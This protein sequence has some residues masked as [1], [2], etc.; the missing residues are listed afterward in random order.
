MDPSDYN[1]KRNS[2]Y[3]KLDIND[4]FKKEGFLVLNAQERADMNNLLKSL[5]NEKGSRKF[6]IVVPNGKGEIAHH[7]DME[8]N[9]LTYRIIQIRGDGNCLFNA[10]SMLL[11][12]DQDHGL[13]LK[14]LA[15]YFCAEYA[16]WGMMQAQHGASIMVDEEMKEF[17][18]EN[19]K[20]GF[21]T[22]SSNWGSLMEAAAL[23]HLLKIHV[24][25]ADRVS[26]ITYRFGEPDIHVL[27]FKI[28][29]FQVGILY[30][31]LP[32]IHYEF[33]SMNMR[34]ARNIIQSISSDAVMSRGFA[35]EYIDVR[36]SS[37][38]H[39]EI[40]RKAVT[41]LHDIFEY[42]G[43]VFCVS[44]KRYNQKPTLLDIQRTYGN[45]R[46]VLHQSVEY[47]MPMIEVGLNRME[48]KH[49][50]PILLEN[51]DSRYILKIYTANNNPRFSIFREFEEKDVFP[52]VDIETKGFIFKEKF[53]STKDQIKSELDRIRSEAEKKFEERIKLY[54]DDK[55]VLDRL[56]RRVQH[57]GEDEA[58]GL[59]DEY[60]RSE[61]LVPE[62]SEYIDELRKH[63]EAVDSGGLKGGEAGKVLNMMQ[64]KLHD[65]FSSTI[66][67]QMGL[68]FRGGDVN[69]KDL[70]ERFS[71]RGLISRQ[72]DLEDM[73]RLTPD[74]IISV[75]VNTGHV[76]A[77]E[78]VIETI[79]PGESQIYIIDFTCSVVP[80]RAQNEKKIK[81]DSIQKYMSEIGFVSDVIAVIL[82]LNKTEVE[83][84]LKNSFI[85]DEIDQRIKEMATMFN[86]FKKQM[87]LKF[88]SDPDFNRTV[89]RDVIFNPEAWD[90][91]FSLSINDDEID[92]ELEE[93][94]NTFLK[95]SGRE[96]LLKDLFINYSEDNPKFGTLQS[97]I[98]RIVKEVKEEVL[99]EREK[100]DN[101]FKAPKRKNIKD[102]LTKLFKD[103]KDYYEEIYESKIISHMPLTSR[104]TDLPEGL[105]DDSFQMNQ[106]HRFSKAIQLADNE[107]EIIRSLKLFFKITD[108]TDQDLK[109]LKNG[110]IFFDSEGNKI[111]SADY[112]NLKGKEISPTEDDFIVNTLSI[113]KNKQLK[114]TKPEK[115][116]DYMKLLDSVKS[117][118]GRKRKENDDMVDRLLDKLSDKIES[119][120]FW[121][122]EARNHYVEEYTLLREAL[123]FDFI[124][125]GQTLNTDLGDLTSSY[126]KVNDFLKG[127]FS[128]LEDYSTFY[129]NLSF[130]SSLGTKSH[131]LV[132]CSN[133]NIIGFTFPSDSILK[134]GSKRSYIILTLVPKDNPLATNMINNKYTVYDCGSDLLYVTKGKCET[135]KTLAT[136][137]VTL[138]RFVLLCS[139]ILSLVERHAKEVPKFGHI[140]SMLADLCML[141][142]N[143]NINNSSIFDNLRY[144]ISNVLSDFSAAGEYIEEKLKVPCKNIFQVYILDRS[145]KTMLTVN[146]EASR[147]KSRSAK[148]DE[149]SEIIYDDFNLAECAVSSFLIP[150]IKYDN[151][152]ALLQEVVALFFSSPKG[153]HDPFH[154]SVKLHKTP[155]E[156]QDKIN[157]KRDKSKK[158][159]L[160]SFNDFN[161]CERHEINVDVTIAASYLAHEE[162]SADSTFL[163]TRLKGSD[164]EKNILIVPTFT[165]TRSMLKE[166]DFLNHKEIKT[167]SD[168]AKNY[169]LDHQSL[170][171]IAMYENDIKD[172]L[173]TRDSVSNKRDRIDK[174]TR[175]LKNKIGDEVF[176]N[177]LNDSMKIDFANGSIVIKFE[178]EHINR[179]DL[180]L[181]DLKKHISTTVVSEVLERSSNQNLIGKTA[182]DFVKDKKT[183]VYAIRPKMQ[184]TQNDREIYV[185]N[186]EAKTYG[187]CIETVYK[188][189][190][191][192]HDYEKISSPGD[193][194]ILDM[195]NQF[196]RQMKWAAHQLEKGAD[197]KDLKVLHMNLDFTKW[198]PKDNIL[199]YIIL[200][201]LNK[202]LRKNEKRGLIYCLIMMFRKKLFID[203]KLLKTMLYNRKK[204]A[205]D[206]D[207]PDCVFEKMT[208]NFTT[209]YVDVK[210]NW[211][212]GQ[213]NYASSF[214]HAG[215]MEL[216]KLCI[217]EIYPI[218]LSF[219]NVHSDDNQT[220]LSVVSTDSYERVVKNS[221]NI[222]MTI[223]KN[224]TMELSTKKCYFSRFIKEFVSQMNIAGEQHFYWVKPLMAIVSGLP[225]TTIY[226]DLMSM[227]SK[228]SEAF[229]KGASTKSFRL[230][231]KL[232]TKE[233]G[234]IYGL[235][236][237][238]GN[239]LA[240]YFDVEDNVLPLS[241][242]GI[243]DIPAEIL[244]VCGP[245]A[246]DKWTLM[247]LLDTCDCDVNRAPGRLPSGNEATTML[248]LF[249]LL[250]SLSE[251]VV[252]DEDTLG[253]G[254]LNPF[255]PIRYKLR[256]EN[257][258]NPYTKENQKKLK[259]EIEVIK[260]DRPS[261]S[262]IK[263]KN[264]EDLLKYYKVLFQKD[265]FKSKLSGQSPDSLMLHKILNKATGGNFSLTNCAFLH[266]LNLS[267]KVF[268]SNKLCSN[269]FDWAEKT[270]RKMTVGLLRRFWTTHILSDS[271]FCAVWYTSSKA[272]DQGLLQVRNLIP[273]KLAKVSNENDFVN[274]MND[275]ILYFFDPEAFIKDKRELN[276]P[277]L[278]N[279]DLMK[280]LVVNP[281]MVI[282]SFSLIINHPAKY[283]NLLRAFNEISLL[284]DKK[285]IFKNSIED[286]T[287]SLP[288]LPST[289]MHE[290]F[291]IGK[292]DFGA[293]NI[294]D[295]IED[296]EKL[297][298]KCMSK[299]LNPGSRMYFV[300]WG[301]S[302]N[303]SDIILGLKKAYS[304]EGNF[305]TNYTIVDTQMRRYWFN[306]FEQQYE[307]IW[308]LNTNYEDML[309]GY[310]LI[311]QNGYTTFED[312]KDACENFYLEVGSYTSSCKKIYFFD[313]L[314]NYE[315]LHDGVKRRMLIP[316]VNLYP[317]K[318]DLF[319]KYH[320]Y[321]SL[322]WVSTQ[323]G[324]K[325][326]E[327][328]SVILTNTN[329]R[330]TVQGNGNKIDKIL[331]NYKDRNYLN[332]VRIGLIR[333][334]K[335]LGCKKNNSLGP[336]I[337][338]VS[339]LYTRVDHTS[340]A[341]SQSRRLI[342]AIKKNEKIP[343]TYGIIDYS[344]ITKMKETDDLPVI[345][346][347]AL[348]GFWDRVAEVDNETKDVNLLRLKVFPGMNNKNLK[349]PVKGGIFDL[350][351]IVIMGLVKDFCSGKISECSPGI[352]CY[353]LQDSHYAFRRYGLFERAFHEALSGDTE[354]L[355]K[356]LRSKEELKFIQ[357][358]AEEES[359]ATKHQTDEK[360]A[361][362]PTI[363]KEALLK[364][365][366]ANQNKEYMDEDLLAK[367]HKDL[368][369]VFAHDSGHT[370]GSQKDFD[371]IMAVSFYLA[372]ILGHFRGSCAV[373]K[374]NS[375]EV[376]KILALST[377]KLARI[378]TAVQRLMLEN[379]SSSFTF[380]KE[381]IERLSSRNESFME[382]LKIALN[383]ISSIT[384]KREMSEIAGRVFGI[385]Q[386][387]QFGEFVS[388][389]ASSSSS[390]TVLSFPS[391]L[392]DLEKKKSSLK[393]AEDIDFKVREMSYDLHTYW[394]NYK[395]QEKAKQSQ[396][397]SRPSTSE[398]LTT[399]ED[400][401]SSPDIINLT[402][403]EH[404][405]E[406]NKERVED[407]DNEE[408]VV[409]DFDNLDTDSDD[410]ISEYQ[411]EGYY[412]NKQDDSFN[413]VDFDN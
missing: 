322:K 296:L 339:L 210:E 143:V 291:R 268:D 219:V 15:A 353:C 84:E 186:L 251:E 36:S 279:S 337:N 4:F 211:F 335:D 85:P 209:A 240:R 182:K 83:C 358:M 242:C 252:D 387:V 234:M 326:N 55:R 74:L 407:S 148:H 348:G 49:V 307:T 248:S 302:K 59:N 205:E 303:P 40:K 106:I 362:I 249:I 157:S 50:M 147:I 54:K 410:S 218:S 14:K 220:S 378:V 269:F 212:Q 44:K 118:L 245:T 318:C 368:D 381:F 222:L 48:W 287:F 191:K 109:N 100:V 360:G 151:P 22:N 223:S 320:K 6:E 161:N 266:D 375:D 323:P 41:R 13:K 78:D 93:Q 30:T 402:E 156:I 57:E 42:K 162:V 130:Q 403:L 9:Q 86:V 340:L 284:A 401:S 129:T 371:I 300:P 247:K 306:N 180:P 107:D 101:P 238:K 299:Q 102:S 16:F 343:Q 244:S 92:E 178:D 329:I 288:S 386:D 352:L 229:G 361:D 120:N 280:F 159:D 145:I 372:A 305:W 331:V 336:L 395:L 68:D 132:F 275:C 389:I 325:K 237:M 376:R 12:G 232:V 51:L 193:D 135:S 367:I 349:F 187:F 164:L 408:E 319:E 89:S 179:E 217:E 324:I 81:Y 262:V 409:V 309:I 163:R 310:K 231:S 413:S 63:Q 17:N 259:E 330:M 363:L 215:V 214:F 29:H 282:V 347:K 321:M 119:L 404:K 134:S 165:S 99:S 58:D 144:L 71:T 224:T 285:A 264:K 5:L 241:L 235:Y 10:I 365:R 70:I 25:L 243:P 105:N 88:G 394:I 113:D 95:N 313:Y 21:W 172:V 206:K 397:G 255:K 267:T 405:Y 273:V 23:C 411:Q 121:D 344:L 304:R 263:P 385:S 167:I 146:D 334:L 115:N 393:L 272:V 246:C 391:F 261:I 392:S 390:D 27:D 311:L 203:H 225:Y 201:L 166:V 173:M 62:A 45:I 64:H 103:C 384:V 258:K 158:T 283:S 60:L 293:S 286:L 345:K 364:K 73:K 138:S 382:P 351:K 82:D 61:F 356:Y 24:F 292:R 8:G 412:G 202:A 198:S 116:A 253:S 94:F 122:T 7:V 342:M 398:K 34:T 1:K 195:K 221:T 72:D 207:V 399:P 19:Y 142:C 124:A 350:N 312:F 208:Q 91:K 254:K 373:F 140:I 260:R 369:K 52:T 406:F 199:K 150:S 359:A 188:E 38:A 233:V 154:N 192:C 123:I 290:F 104:D 75:N 388:T 139:T 271:K 226:D 35:K 79:N 136:R 80:K 194:K 87:L 69:M 213:L 20:R 383:S 175:E 153:L 43:D 37:F 46:R 111:G 168:L 174:L 33:S 354:N 400:L 131:R 117:S 112:E 18:K 137:C 65:D 370:F 236:D 171:L 90:L 169:E 316:L 297:L 274:G 114:I 257:I 47:N 341:Y 265:S 96:D 332:D 155:L 26:N 379:T 160:E 3:N 301:T 328:F 308:M 314:N 295:L 327:H 250:E 366:E 377:C 141:V 183:A 230:I 227:Y 66:M 56:N 357:K 170:R 197:I 317:D 110:R 127:A 39:D 149:R 184:R 11:F 32:E 204:L 216:W 315:A 346:L 228:L 177:D 278:I 239:K 196:E 2:N 189:F 31:D 200:I 67:K 77:L 28:N 125:L 374:Y 276:F 128:Y 53:K 181:K 289:L 294:P 270:K 380:M 76:Q 176:F 185:G 298:Q 355:S 281:F 126:D 256:R 108:L 152:M 277:K 333:L 98:N 338:H 133:P 190:S 396:D 97:R